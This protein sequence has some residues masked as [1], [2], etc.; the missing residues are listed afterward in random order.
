MLNAETCNRL[1]RKGFTLIELLIVIAIIAILASMLLPAL[2][3]ARESARTKA[4][5][6]N[7]KTLILAYKMYVDDYN[8]WLLAARNKKV[9][10][11]GMWEGK[12]VNSGYLGNSKS[13]KVF[14]CPSEPLQTIYNSSKGFGYTHYALNAWVCGEWY[15]QVG[16][17]PD[18]V[19]RRET[20]IQ[21]P[22]KAIILLDSRRKDNNV[23]DD[24]IFIGYRHG[25]NGNFQIV[26]S[27]GAYRG[28]MANAAYFDG[29]AAAL[30]RVQMKYADLK[31]GVSN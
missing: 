22:G 12:L 21:S 18:I 1:I 23:L 30:K 4:C 9:G 15:D 25:G 10:T 3:T 26:L 11:A 8:G 2:G 13:Y 7:V 14:T 31:A 27:S 24:T 5:L 17:K 19:A 28:K 16:S 20:S 29:H 6:S